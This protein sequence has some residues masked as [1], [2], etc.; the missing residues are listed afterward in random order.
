MDVSINFIF[1]KEMNKLIDEEI[2]KDGNNNV[3]T[4]MVDGWSFVKNTDSHI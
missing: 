3:G 4:Q 1:K 2:Q